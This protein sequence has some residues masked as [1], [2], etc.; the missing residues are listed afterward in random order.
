[1][2]KI[3]KQDD[4]DRVHLREDVNTSLNYYMH[5]SAELISGVPGIRMTK[6]DF[7][8]ELL[9]NFLSAKGHYP[10]KN[11]DDNKK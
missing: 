10:P 8:N 5:E 7:V 4:I 3:V 9:I 2:P 6:A 11:S 1:M